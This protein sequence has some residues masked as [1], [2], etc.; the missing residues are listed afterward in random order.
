MIN[1]NFMRACAKLIGIGTDGASAIIANA[2]LKGI[3]ESKIS[4]LVSGIWC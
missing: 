3:L 4:W 2:G 1:E